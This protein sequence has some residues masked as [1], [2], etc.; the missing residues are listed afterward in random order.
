M[1]EEQEIVANTEQQEIAEEQIQHTPQPISA[2][3]EENLK[4]IRQSKERAER[5][6]DEAIRMM[7]QM[8]QMK[9][10]PIPEEDE[11][12]LNP[13][14]LVE[15][16]HVQ[17][18]MKKQEQKIQQQQQQMAESMTEARIKAQFPDF[19]Q[20]VTPD[21]IAALRDADP[22]YAAIIN[23]HPDMYMKAVS[24]Y[25]QIKRLGLNP[26]IQAFASEK[27]RAAKNVSKPKPLASVAPQQGDTP[28]SRAN[29]FASGLT[30]E[31]K[32]QLRKE[33]EEARKNL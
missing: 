10:Q 29:A 20:I 19:D 6:R 16:K 22:E 26:D 27:E 2:K 21:N 23:A 11:P 30:P 5:E 25:K 28:L 8:Q 17:K 13:D 4:I 18:M 32:E 12:K 3:A 31:L 24:V 9:V 1:F 14:D 15:W 33:M 7:Q